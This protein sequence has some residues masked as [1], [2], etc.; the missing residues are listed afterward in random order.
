MKIT[1][2]NHEYGSIRKWTIMT[3]RSWLPRALW[4]RVYRRSF[5][6]FVDGLDSVVYDLSSS[7]NRYQELNIVQT[8]KVWSVHRWDGLPSTDNDNKLFLCKRLLQYLDCFNILTNYLGPCV[9]N[10][11]IRT[12]AAKPTIYQSF[13]KNVFFALTHRPPG[14]HCLR[15]Y[16]YHLLCLQS[17]KAVWKDLNVGLVAT[18]VFRNII[19]FTHVLYLARRKLRNKFRH[20]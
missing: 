16:V 3:I 11:G 12:F 20:N 18:G 5:L 9:W 1:L 13:Y 14:S 7:T 19:I 2:L 4:C 17:R 6:D 10:Y 15:V 8:G